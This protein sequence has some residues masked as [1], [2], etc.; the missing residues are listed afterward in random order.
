[1]IVYMCLCWLLGLFWLETVI[2]VSRPRFRF[3]LAVFPCSGGNQL[4][5]C[6]WKL[7]EMLFR[8]LDVLNS[9]H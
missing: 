4:L 8:D 9:R 2:S 1:M 6:E 5:V 7:A 3:A